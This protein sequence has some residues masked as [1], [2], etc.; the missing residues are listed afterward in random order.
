MHRSGSTSSAPPQ[1]SVPRVRFST[2]LSSHGTP[3]DTPSEIDIDNI[4]D[5][6]DDGEGGNTIFDVSGRSTSESEPTGSDLSDE[7]VQERTQEVQVYVMDDLGQ[8]IHRQTGLIARPVGGPG[9]VLSG[10]YNLREAM[11]WAK[12][13]FDDM[14]VC[15]SHN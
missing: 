10:G 8:R 6:G 13:D 12:D 4:S 15:H 14:Q 2:P 5:G 11:K 7:D 1:S 9:R 3:S